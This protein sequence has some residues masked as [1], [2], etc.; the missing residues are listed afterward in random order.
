MLNVDAIVFDQ[1]NTLIMDPFADIMKRKA[2]P[3][4]ELFKVYGLKYDSRRITDAWTLSNRVVNYSFI[5]HFSQEEPIIQHALRNL[6]VPPE[7]ACFLGPELLREFRNGLRDF[8]KADRHCQAA[9]EVL[10]EL[11]SRGKRLGVFS[12][13]RMIGLAMV[14]SFMGIENLFEYIETSESTGMEKPDPGVFVHVLD[15]FKLSPRSV[16]YV[17]DDPVRDI[18]TAKSAGLMAALYSVDRE[19]YNESWRDYRAEARYAPDLV[20]SDFSELLLMI[21]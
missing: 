16:L 1:G 5:G 6:N 19:K 2:G 17:G 8:I 14:L 11:K 12:N 3:F 10:A 4:T 7:I 20:I 13:D 9:G 15:F 18:D 21:E